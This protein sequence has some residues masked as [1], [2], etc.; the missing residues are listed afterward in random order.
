MAAAPAHAT[1]PY[2]RKPAPLSTPWTN[3]VSTTAPLPEYPRPQLERDSWLNLN[4]RWQFEPARAH[5][6]SPFGR[7]LAQTILVPFPVQSPLSGIE[8]PI[9]SGWYRRTF[10]A[11]DAWRRK[12]V[13][14]NFGAVSWAARVYVNGRLAGTHRGDYD[15]FSLDITALLRGTGANELVVG[16]S[17]PIGRAQEPVGKQIPGSPYGYHHTAA[18]GIWQTVWL[19]AVSARHL[20][21]LDLMPDL[22][23]GSLTLNAAATGD[24]RDGRPLRAEALVSGRVVARATG[25]TG[26]PLTL[27]IPHPRAWSPSDPYLY[28]LRVS[29]LDRG[30]VVDLVRSY[31]GLRSIG[32]G[33]AGGFTR[34]LLN[35]SF[36]FQ[37]GAL[38]QGYWPDGLYTA[39]TDAALRY[40]LLAAKRLGFNMLREHVKVEPARF[41]LWA[42]RLGILIWQDMP[43]MPLRGAAHPGAAARAEFARE[44]SAVVRQHRSEP[45]IVAWVPFNEGWGAFDPPGITGALRRLDPTRPIDTD[46]G[47]ANCCGA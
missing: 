8:R 28:D 15:S 31:F 30:R 45:A 3:S 47:S 25:R 2:V 26:R 19:E 21:D 10:R 27:V 34:L 36:L 6:R 11:P 4:G 43:N 33:Q 12:R 17:D 23:R 22:A 46:S 44:L 32:L 5:Q 38:A 29:L 42:A 7:D 40:D 13:I 18:S 35:G 41:Y 20:T 39:P 24:G 9:T 14:L 16:Y 1:A 37:S